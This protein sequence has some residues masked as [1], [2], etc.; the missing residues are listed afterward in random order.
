MTE[1]HNE[2]ETL[3]DHG[4]AAA[5][6]LA[7]VDDREA[8]AAAFRSLT[9][10]DAATLLLSAIEAGGT[11]VRLGDRYPDQTPRSLLGALIASCRAEEA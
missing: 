10:G 3:S 8:M 7:A 5:L 11:L 4:D 1:D 6:M 2:Q 9:L